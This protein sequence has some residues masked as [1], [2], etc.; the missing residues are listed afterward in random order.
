MAVKA[1][2]PLVDCILALDC[3]MISEKKE[4]SLAHPQ[5]QQ[6]GL[7]TLKNLQSFCSC[8]SRLAIDVLQ[9]ERYVELN[10]EPEL[11]VLASLIRWKEKTERES[12]GEPTVSDHVQRLRALQ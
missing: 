12:R 2:K 7:C 10:H 5:T 8:L 3:L 1:L 9:D 6:Q 11:L 4:V